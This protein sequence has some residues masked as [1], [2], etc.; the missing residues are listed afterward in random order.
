MAKTKYKKNRLVIIIAIIILSATLLVISFY[1]G[2][3]NNRSNIVL[4]EKYSNGWHNFSFRYNTGA[5]VVFSDSSLTPW[6]FYISILKD[7]SIHSCSIQFVKQTKGIAQQNKNNTIDLKEEKIVVKDKEWTVSQ[8]KKQPSNYTNQYTYWKTTQDDYYIYAFSDRAENNTYCEKILS[9]LQFKSDENIPSVKE[10]KLIKNV[11]REYAASD[12]PS[13]VFI[14]AAF[15]YEDL[16][17][18]RSAFETTNKAIVHFEDPNLDIDLDR[19]YLILDKINGVW[20][21]IDVTTSD[22]NITIP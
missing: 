12:F 14:D 6:N 18:R 10:A 16:L 13:K 20:K 9:T 7:G 15:V 5:K 21:V 4:S 2:K 11:A 19:K 1:V 22:P 8:T 17:N 3:F